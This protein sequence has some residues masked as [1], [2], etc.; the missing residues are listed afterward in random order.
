MK[1]LDGLKALA[2]AKPPAMG[3][4]ASPDVEE[5]AEDPKR[6]ELLQHADAL[7]AAIKAGD[8]EAVADVL[9]ACGSGYGGSEV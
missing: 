9:E 5:P 7:I 2:T 3:A 6:A 4:M 1:G 8:R